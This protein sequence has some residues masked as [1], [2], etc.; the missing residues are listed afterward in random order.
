MNSLIPLCN[1]PR[2]KTA[3]EVRHEHLYIEFNFPLTFIQCNADF[4]CPSSDLADGDDLPFDDDDTT[5]TDDSQQQQPQSSIEMS[6]EQPGDKAHVDYDIDST[7][8]WYLCIVLALQ[9][10]KY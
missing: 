10:R 7:P 4:R 9:V 1:V 3:I 8:P 5:A 2:S 6:S